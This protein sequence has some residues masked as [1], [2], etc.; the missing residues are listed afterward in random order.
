MVEERKLKALYIVVYLIIFFTVWS[1]R[2]LVIRPVWLN[3]FDGLTWHILE[4]SMKLVVWTVPAIFLI[5]YFEDDMWINFKEMFT[6]KPR[7]FKSAPLLLLVFYPL[8]N[9]LFVHGEI[10]VRPGFEPLSLIQGVMFAGIT[11]DIVFRG[12]L[13]NTMLKRMKAWQ[14][15][16]VDAVLFALIHCPIWIYWGF[17]FTDI[18][19]SIV[20]VLP[21]SVLFAFSFIKTKNLLVP[22]TLHMIW[23]ILMT[24][25]VV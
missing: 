17:G 25:F 4:S 11:E 20:A 9:A 6:N 13:L 2:E 14:A 7:W 12:F 5:I 18:L 1:I 23:N 3:Q 19:L 24:L 16:A 15:V 21:T 10:A 22:I 8:A